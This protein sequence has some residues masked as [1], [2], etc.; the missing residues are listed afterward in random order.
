MALAHLADMGIDARRLDTDPNAILSTLLADDDPPLAHLRAAYVVFRVAR[1]H[2]TP[3]DATLLVR[4]AHALS[5]TSRLSWLARTM[6][7]LT[8]LS[9]RHG[10]RD[11]DPSALDSIALRVLGA[12]HASAR[13]PEDTTRVAAVDFHKSAPPN[14][15]SDDPAPLNRP[16]RS[17]AAVRASRMTSAFRRVLSSRYLTDLPRPQGMPSRTPHLYTLCL[18]LLAD[19]PWPWHLA[20]DCAQRHITAAARAGVNVPAAALNVLLRRARTA[21]AP[22]RPS[23]AAFFM[24]VLRT[25]PLR[26]FD[27]G[28]FAEFAQARIADPADVA[29]VFLASD[30]PWVRDLVFVT[31]ASKLRGAAVPAAAKPRDVT[32]LTHVMEQLVTSER[33]SDDWPLADAVVAAAVVA[34]NHDAS[35]LP[36]RFLN[37][38]MEGYLQSNQPDKAW[39]VLRT[40]VRE[41]NRHTLNVLFRSLRGTHDVPRVLETAAKWT[42]RVLPDPMLAYW[43]VAA[44]LRG[45]SGYAGDGA[46][47]AAQDLLDAL[48]ADAPET[49]MRAAG[50]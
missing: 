49:P 34:V 43:V 2:S 36:T 45:D 11:T 35:C 31:A 23:D 15:V 21:G 37:A 8:Y 28:T 6:D 20:R 29:R 5:T 16:A 4:L 25:V 42:G 46:W 22:D 9:R 18:V 41:P 39:H 12:L 13:R 48:L 17:P 33:T 50:K 26:W 10:G 27:D 1:C 38:V 44:I 30:K 19:T 32:A 47:T 40:V 3:M 24:H 7:V 14:S